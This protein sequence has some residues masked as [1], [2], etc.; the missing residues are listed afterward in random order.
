MGSP[1]TTRKWR[2]KRKEISSFRVS[3]HLLPQISNVLIWLSFFGAGAQEFIGNFELE[4]D[5]F[6]S[7]TFLPFPVILKTIPDHESV[8]EETVLVLS[9][10][11]IV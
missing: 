2:S 1:V 8:S 3:F 7:S 10:D 5:G 11:H 9:Q 4:A 6:F